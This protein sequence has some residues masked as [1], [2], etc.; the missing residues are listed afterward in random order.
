MLAEFRQFSD[1]NLDTLLDVYSQSLDQKDWSE[2]NDFLEDLQLF[3]KNKNVCVIQW[4]EDGKAVAA[5]RLEPY[6]DGS[7]ITCLETHPHYR[8]KGYAYQLLE[9]VLSKYP[10][11]YYSH[12]DKRNKPSLQLHRKV[13]FKS[14]LDYAIHVDGSVYSGSV[15]L[16][17]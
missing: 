9:S 17:K 12:V 15:T 3:Y 6:Q 13:G 16:K 14:F 1:V 7:L 8:R 11:I 5:M 4:I 2:V 10:G